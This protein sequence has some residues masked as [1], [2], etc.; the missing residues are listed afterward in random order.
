MQ[1]EYIGLVGKKKV[2][3]TPYSKGRLKSRNLSI[4]E[5]LETL[6]KR[7]I[8]YPKE[9]DGRQKIRST[10]GNKKKVFLVI[11]EDNN[12]ILIITGGEA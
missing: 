10:L 8:N 4:K 3:V 11:K 2:Y 5:V 6:K 7:E 12:I 1:L 9:I